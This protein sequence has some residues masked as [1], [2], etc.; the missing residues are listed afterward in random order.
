MDVENQSDSSISVIVTV[1]ICSNN[2]SLVSLFQNLIEG[3]TGNR[4]EEK[5]EAAAIPELKIDPALPPEE[6][7]NLLVQYL[8]GLNLDND[9]SAVEHH[10]DLDLWDF[11][12]QHLYYTFCP[13]FFSWRAVY[14]LVYN[15]SKGLNE[16]A[17]PCFRRGFLNIPLENTNR[18]TNLENLL[19]WLVTLSSVC[20]SKPEANEKTLSESDLLYTRPPVF[21]VGTHADRKQDQDVKEMELQITKEIS[22]K[23]YESHVIRP[24]FSVDNTQGSSDKGV[25]ALQKKIIEVLK[26]EPYMGEEI[27]LRYAYFQSNV[28]QSKL[29]LLPGLHSFFF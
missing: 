19:S 14:L 23:D 21:I 22:E 5:I 7:T 13:V 16:I 9:T 29:N 2:F 15:L 24:F 1:L 6:F 3:T 25:A 18:Q 28:I 4:G 20:T 12:G 10:M 27:P 17:M 8:E 11:A 26:K